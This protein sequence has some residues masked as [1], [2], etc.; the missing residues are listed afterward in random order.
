MLLSFYISWNIASIKAVFWIWSNEKYRSLAGKFNCITSDLS[1]MCHVALKDIRQKLTSFSTSGFESCQAWLS[2]NSRVCPFRLII[3]AKVN[4]FGHCRFLIN[5]LISL[6]IKCTQSEWK[7]GRSN[8][9]NS[10]KS[11]AAIGPDP[12]ATLTALTQILDC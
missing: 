10:Y 4:F 3:W 12:D 8:W 7:N 9:M 1:K 2:T 5:V 6:N 11:N